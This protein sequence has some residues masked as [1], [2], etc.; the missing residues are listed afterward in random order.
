MVEDLL[1]TKTQTFLKIEL[2]FLYMFC[3]LKYHFPT[4]LIILCLS[5]MLLELQGKLG[6]LSNCIFIVGLITE[7]GIQE[8]LT[9]NFKLLSRE[10]IGARFSSASHQFY[11]QKSRRYTL[12]VWLLQSQSLKIH[13]TIAYTCFLNDNQPN[14]LS[15]TREQSV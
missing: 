12:Q 4:V 10:L 14:T 15:G 7:W 3:P 1:L 2:N 9:Q 5:L 13:A 11:S 8:T 6:T